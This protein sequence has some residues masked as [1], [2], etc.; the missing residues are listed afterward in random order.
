MCL[1]LP[2]CINASEKQQQQKRLMSFPVKML[3]DSSR[4][5]V[6]APESFLVIPSKQGISIP[7]ITYLYKD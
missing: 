6:C 5:L 3:S 1:Y 4:R 2:K 7:S